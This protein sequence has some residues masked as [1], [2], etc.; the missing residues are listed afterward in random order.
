VLRAFLAASLTDLSAEAAR[1]TD[2]FAAA[3]HEGYRQLACLCAVGVQPYAADHV[4]D[5]RFLQA[6]G[7]AMVARHHACMACGDAILVV[8]VFLVRHSCSLGT[9]ME[10]ELWPRSLLHWARL[11]TRTR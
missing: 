1:G 4:L 9:G 3:G 11:F 2:V 7:R 8:L 6:A 5:V 10:L